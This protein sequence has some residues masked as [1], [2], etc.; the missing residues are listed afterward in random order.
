MFRELLVLALAA[1]CLTQA[2]TVETHT[3]DMKLLHKQKK[4]YE[5]FFYMDQPL[6][7]GS[8]AYEVGRGYDIESNMDMYTDKVIYILLKH[9]KE[10]V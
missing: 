1:F 9:P 8:E 2:M 6:V 5:L 10:E 7:V 3:A 4:V